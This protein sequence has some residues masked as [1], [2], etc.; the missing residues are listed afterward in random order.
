MIRMVGVHLDTGAIRY[1]QIE[2]KDEADYV[3]WIN[4]CVDALIENS[5]GILGFTKHIYRVKNIIAIEFSDPPA[6]GE[7][8]PVGL[9]LLKYDK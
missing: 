9:R 1:H 5:E 6:E 2:V 7:S 3:K 8:W 4:R